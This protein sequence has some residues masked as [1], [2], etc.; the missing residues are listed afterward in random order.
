MTA[1]T[2]PIKGDVNLRL[3]RNIKL[4]RTEAGLSQRGLG[5]RAG[6]P[7]PHVVSMEN[8]NRPISVESVLKISHALGLDYG[9]FFV[10]HEPED[11]AL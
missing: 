9:W 11:D 4:A 3:A 2:P 10:E 6:I 1:T 8:G 7:R 5:E